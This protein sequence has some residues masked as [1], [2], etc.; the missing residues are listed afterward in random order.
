MLGRCLSELSSLLVNTV[1]QALSR[2]F[3]VGM[4]WEFFSANYKV[5]MATFHEE[6]V[7]FVKELC[8]KVYTQTC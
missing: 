4:S 8:M 1:L 6:Y 3:R 5:I 7:A 2:K